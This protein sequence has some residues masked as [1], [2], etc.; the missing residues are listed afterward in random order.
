MIKICTGWS[1]PGG[2][3]TAF[4]NLCNLFNESGHECTMYGPHDWHLTKCKGDNINNAKFT[5]TDKVIYHFLDVRK[6]RLPVD[7][8]ILSLHEK[9]LYPLKQKPA[10]IFD[11][12]HFLNK[13]QLMWHEAHTIKNL[14]W[15]ICGNVN[16]NLKPTNK[17]KK[18]TAGI[19]GSIDRNKQVHISIERAIKDGHN[20][21]RIYGSIND[22]EYWQNE[23][24][25]VVEKYDKKVTVVGYT[26]NKQEIYDTV[27]D[28]Y[29]SSL[30]ENASLVSDE[31]KLTN[32][33]FHGNENI[34]EQSLWS[35]VAILRIWREQLEL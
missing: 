31:C 3:T 16:E 24:R 14:S 20:D 18:K 8:F 5:P 30:S 22:P 17:E 32:V 15:F 1:N 28:V 33:N 19:I 34:I 13:E 7:K 27:T 4:I 26:E 35:N 29:Q 12:I 9:D 6:T 11:K 25:P 2:S 21:I 23:V 10:H